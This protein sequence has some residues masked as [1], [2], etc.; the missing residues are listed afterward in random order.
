MRKFLVVLLVICIATAILCACGTTPKEPTEEQTEEKT[1]TKTARTVAEDH[2][3][4]DEP[5]ITDYHFA[6]G[7]DVNTIRLEVYNG[8]GWD[9]A[10]GD[11][12]FD[13]NKPT[14]I[15]AHGLGPD[16]HGRAPE[17]LYEKG[18]NVLNFLWGTFS[19]NSL[20]IKHVGFQIWHGIDRYEVAKTGRCVQAEGFDCTVAEIY[21]AR[22]CDFFKNYPEYSLPIVMTG[23]S[24]GGQL[25]CAMSGI[26]TKYLNDNKLNP[27]IF[28]DKFML[29]DPYFDNMN[30]EYDCKWFG[31]KFYGS[32]IA[33]GSAILDYDI[34]N[35]TPIEILRTSYLVKMA[36]HMGDTAREKAEVNYTRDIEMK[37]LYLELANP[38]VIMNYF[39][40][41]L[42]E[43]GGRLHSVAE[44]ITL[45]VLRDTP[46]V[47]SSGEVLIGA[48]DVYLDDNG[49]Y[50][51]GKFAPASY[52]LAARGI[53]Y[54][55][56]LNDPD[57]NQYDKLTLTPTYFDPDWV[58]ADDE[59][60][61]EEDRIYL[62][63]SW[64]TESYSKVAGFINADV[65]SNGVYDDGASS[66][67]TDVTVVLKDA[68]GKVVDKCFT[69]KGYY[70]FK[71][72]KNADY[73]VEIDS[74]N[75]SSQT[76]NVKAD[77]IINIVDFLASSK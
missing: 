14:F 66:R 60:P 56:Y 26:M 17:A 64:F 38:D 36:T 61:S 28:P 20:G 39:N 33:A 27:K 13:P 4:Y 51:Y 11:S 55:L 62:T 72:T 65:N 1:I 3:Q 16:L 63:Y 58:N 73:T 8:S 41:N 42:G 5:T 24:Y 12:A 7:F 54:D 46:Y 43:G 15:F 35:N 34:A 6:E 2:A 22:Y 74:E 40:G 69:N 75:Y 9:F 31:Q 50:V 32:S 37:V 57:F 76:K 30:Y 25:T 29:I 45:T 53:H 67:L 49:N 19:G 21:L 48:K 52:S 18:Y 70:E 71:V 77:G 59:D 23:H 68:N 44:D 47:K 10:D